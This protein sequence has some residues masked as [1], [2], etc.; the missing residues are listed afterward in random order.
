MKL[1]HSEVLNADAILRYLKQPIT[2]KSICKDSTYIQQWQKI[3]VNLKY[4]EAYL[5]IFRTS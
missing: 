3:L 1:D 4:N 2:V 5:Q